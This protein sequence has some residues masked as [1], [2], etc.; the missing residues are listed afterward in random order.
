MKRSVAAQRRATKILFAG[1]TCLEGRTRR[2]AEK[3]RTTYIAH[4]PRQH[5]AVES[6]NREGMYSITL[7]RQFILE[8]E[9]TGGKP[10]FTLNTR[11]KS[12]QKYPQSSARRRTRAAR[13]TV[14]APLLAR[15]P[16][17]LSI[18]MRSNWLRPRRRELIP[19]CYPSVSCEASV[20]I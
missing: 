20:S 3:Q 4:L 9:L 19:T 11:N 8:A 14:A 10:N 17:L 13:V 15:P 7:A 12:I 16:L 1:L 6:G 18:Q 2:H 5:K